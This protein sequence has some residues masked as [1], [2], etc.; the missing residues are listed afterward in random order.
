MFVTGG[1]RVL[2]LT[3]LLGDLPAVPLA[4]IQM[5]ARPLSIGGTHEFLESMA[6]P[7]WP[8]PLHKTLELLVA[9][10]EIGVR[11]VPL[12]HIVALLITALDAPFRTTTAIRVAE[13][14]VLRPNA[15]MVGICHAFGASHHRS[16]LRTPRSM[17]LASVS[18]QRQQQRRNY[19]RYQPCKHGLS[20]MEDKK[21]VT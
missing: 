18:G 15:S 3:T 5:P 6:P 10:L 12:R 8:M 16:L 17:V 1:I 9:A 7:L 2:V 20:L 13:L 21:H 14:L 11:P 19:D 4:R